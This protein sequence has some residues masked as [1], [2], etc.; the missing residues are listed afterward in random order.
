RFKRQFIFDSVAVLSKKYREHGSTLITEHG[1]T[2]GNINA[3]LRNYSINTVFMAKEHTEYETEI[4]RELVKANPGI[5]FQFFED[6]TMLHPGD[7]PFHCSALPELFTT[8]RKEVE[9]DLRVRKPADAVVKLPPTID[10]QGDGKTLEEIAIL[11]GIEK[12]L[13]L[14]FKGGESEG[15]RRL[16]YYLDETQLLSR[17][18]ETRNGLLGDDYSSKFS[19]WLSIGALSPRQIYWAVKEYEEK[20]GAN[21]STYWLVFELLWRDFFRFIAMKHGKKIFLKNSIRGGNAP[22]KSEINMK[23][24]GKWC[25]GETAQPF[26]D[27]NMRELN[28]TGFMSNRGRQNVASYLV[29]DLGLDWRLGA[30]YFESMLLDYDPC[31]NWGNW[32]YLAGVGNDG[33]D[34]RRFNPERQAAMYDPD[35]EYQRAWLKAEG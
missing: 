33:R 16:K 2:I 15:L 13:E 32:I 27:A 34:F 5:E 30:E 17:Y 18:K 7:L 12:G 19:P 24:F 9:K 31:S 28:A 4:E 26:I 23:R 22:G 25:R 20:Y 21:D 10:V 6:R 8:F 1:S 35:G 3:M 11:L 14:R 29:H